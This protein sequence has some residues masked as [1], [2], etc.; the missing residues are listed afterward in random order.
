MNELDKFECNSWK[1]SIQTSVLINSIKERIAEI[2]YDHWRGALL[3]PDA[4]LAAVTSH[5]LLEE[6]L[7]VIDVIGQG[8]IEQMEEAPE[9][10]EVE[11]VLEDDD[12]A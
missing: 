8:N 3:D 11:Y 9:E 12:Y 7:Y 1:N 6:L 5:Q 10:P 2:E 4:N